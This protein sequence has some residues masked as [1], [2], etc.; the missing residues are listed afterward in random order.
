M[1]TGCSVT[2]LSERF[3]QMAKQA[4]QKRRIE[5]E[6]FRPGIVI[7]LEDLVRRA[8]MGYRVCQYP[9][10]TRPTLLYLAED[11]INGEP[12]LH[13]MRAFNA[14]LG[15]G[16]ISEDNYE[17]HVRVFFEFV[18][19]IG[20]N[21]IYGNAYEYNQ[22]IDIITEY[23]KEGGRIVGLA[24]TLLEGDPDVYSSYRTPL[25]RNDCNTDGST[26]GAV[27]QAPLLPQQ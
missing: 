2:T 8:T 9:N 1:H 19:T 5:L 14:R 13:M 22:V 18:S 20:Y 4:K 15:R 6:L 17:D 16:A 25:E 23:E 12:L 3:A 10:G 26:E 7:T 11:A 27:D 21:V 24:W